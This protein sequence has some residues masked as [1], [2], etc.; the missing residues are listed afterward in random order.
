[1][2]NKQLKATRMWHYFV[3]A[4]VAIIEEEG[5]EAVTIRKVADRAGYT[6][7]TIY[8]YFDE[9]SHLIFFA[10]MRFLKDYTKELSYYMDHGKNSLE[11]Y[12]KT[13]ECFCKHSF[14]KPQIYKA[15][16]ISD[17][18]SHPEELLK[19]YYNMNNNDWVNLS[20]E[21][22]TLCMEYNIGKRNRIILEMAAKEGLVNADHLDD[23]NDMAILIW[24]GMM[25][26]VLS[27]REGYTADQAAELTCKYIEA[28]TVNPFRISKDMEEA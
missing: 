26:T 8:N 27:N 4:T 1:M 17:L 11:K 28:I 23:I 2:D 21:V 9:L 7:A 12:L 18:G 25:T 14:H 16:F 15:L 5:M 24:K 6:S 20:K 13:W 22:K 3:D 19:T 10:S